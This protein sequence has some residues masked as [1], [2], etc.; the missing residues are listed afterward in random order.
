MTD[1]RVK[2][3]LG[4][5]ETAWGVMAFEFFTPGLCAV[6]AAGGADFVFLDMEHSGAGIDTIKAQCAFARGA[7][8]APLVRVPYCERHLVTATLDA[9]AAG[10]M[11]P[12]VETPEQAAALAS[13]C[14]Y[15]PEG[16]RGLA[17]GV[18][19]DAYRGGAADAAMARANAAVMAIPLIES[20]RGIRN[21]EAVLAV[22]GIDLGWLGHY[23]LSDSLGCVG[24]F[25][26]PRYA[27]AERALLAAAAKA[28]KPMGWLAGDAEAAKGALARGYRCLCLGTDVALMR[29]AFAAML[30]DARG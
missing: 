12:M 25:A 30:A 11:A 26:D 29:D 3:L 10:I 5:G 7:G 27:A 15:R 8:I 19:H 2:T 22:P 9:G 18:A 4:R 21:A 17:F 16:T 24:D 14:R 28:G 1:N 23:D 20:E 13:W 6:L